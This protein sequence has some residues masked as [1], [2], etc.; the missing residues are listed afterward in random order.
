M[1][2]G[3]V[4]AQLAAVALAVCCMA[5]SSLKVLAACSIAALAVNLCG[6]LAAVLKG[7]E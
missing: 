7:G 4:R 3:F 5:S 6:V 2:M 1:I